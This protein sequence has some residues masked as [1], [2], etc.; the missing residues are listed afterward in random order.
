MSR[1]EEDGT[2]HPEGP[3]DLVRVGPAH[4]RL[5]TFLVL[6]H[7]AQGIF[8]LGKQNDGH[9]WWSME[10]RAVFLTNHIHASRSLRKLVRQGR[11]RVTADTAFD[12]VLGFCR[13]T[14]IG[15]GRPGSWITDEYVQVYSDLHRLGHAHSVETWDG[16]RLVGGLFGLAVGRMFFGC[17]MFHL[18]PN[19]SKV[20]LVR[21]SENLTQWGFPLI[22]CQ[23]YNPHLKRMGAKFLPRGHFHQVVRQLV[24]RSCKIGS[25]TQEF[26]ETN[27]G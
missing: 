17:S 18:Q 5:S 6:F 12:E 24:R 27:S 10:P 20:A 11:Y 2:Q 23:I 15:D 1:V 7:Y 13:N 26:S 8:P 4:E 9:L 16:D 25:W 19:T 21:L 14:R 22:D 3:I